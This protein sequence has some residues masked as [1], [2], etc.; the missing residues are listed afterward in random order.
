[1]RK[2][3]DDELIANALIKQCNHYDFNLYIGHISEYLLKNNNVQEINTLPQENNTLINKFNDLLSSMSVS[4]RNDFLSK[5]H[6]DMYVHFAKLLQ[7]KYIFSGETLGTLASNLLTNLTIGRGS[8][9]QYDVVSILILSFF[10][11]H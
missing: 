7:C 8:Q 2:E 4:S 11:N 3:S 9:V 5:V 1:M 10:N 6:R